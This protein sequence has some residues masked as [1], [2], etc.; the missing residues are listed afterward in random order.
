MGPSSGDAL[1]YW[2]TEQFRFSKAYAFFITALILTAIVAIIAYALPKSH[3]GTRRLIV[4]SPIQQGFDASAGKNIESLIV[5]PSTIAAVSPSSAKK[6]NT[7]VP[8]IAGPV[9]SALPYQFLG[10]PLDRERA[11]SCLAAAQYYEA[12]N[13]E[14]GQRA[15]AQVVLN[16]LRHPAYPKSICGVVFQGQERAT[17]CQFTF[18]CD[19][20]MARKPAGAAWKQARAVAEQMLSGSTYKP[21]GYATHYH[22]D[23][24]VPYW[25][26]SLDKIAAVRTHLF[27]RWKGGW[28][29]PRAFRWQGIVPEPLIT[30]LNMLSSAHSSQNPSEF[31]I[32]NASTSP[33][34]A[35]PHDPG[36]SNVLSQKVSGSV[37]II[38]RLPQTNAFIVQFSD[39]ASPLQYAALAQSVCEGYDRCN[40]MGWTSVQHAPTE[41][42][43]AAGALATMT[44]NYVKETRGPKYSSYW[45]C[46]LL[47]PPSGGRCLGDKSSL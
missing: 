32:Q 6:I 23:W 25:S 27:F 14:E 12:G 21:V 45:N 34:L 8:F 16:R 7:S 18:T 24:V 29:Q 39:D 35:T 30:K 9:T 3:N 4:S 11:I 47:Q 36:T 5:A 2:M 41:F 42:P 28:G 37:R 15:V 10:R 31:E 44:F 1:G 20:A 38:G 40:L 26:S 19:G 17:G 33:E 13:D 46:R 43:L 22:T